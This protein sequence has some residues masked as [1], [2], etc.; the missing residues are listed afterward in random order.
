M[1]MQLSHEPRTGRPMIHGEIYAEL[2]KAPGAWLDVGPYSKQARSD[3]FT[4]AGRWFR[5]HLPTVRLEL[6]NARG[7]L[8][9]RLC[10][11]VG[12]EANRRGREDQTFFSDFGNRRNGTSPTNAASQL[13]A[14]GGPGGEGVGDAGAERA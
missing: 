4:T 6:M 1:T 12:E 3:C 13:I 2:I 14:G 8:I 10:V 11:P 7:R 9:V 5:S